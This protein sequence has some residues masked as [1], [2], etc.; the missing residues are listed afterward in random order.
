MIKLQV[1]D[2][3]FGDEAVT[4]R[5][6]KRVKGK[7]STRQ[8]PLTPLLKEALLAWLSI[9]PGHALFCHGDEVARSKK[10][11][12]STGH[13]SAPGRATSLTGRA[14]TVKARSKPQLGH[15]TTSEMHY[16]FRKTLCE[17]KWSVVK[18]SHVLRHSMISCMAAAGIDQRIIDDTVGHCSEEMRRRYRHLTPEVKQRSVT[19]VFG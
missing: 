17:S 1:T 19:A 10:R 4:I 18:G 11:R 9:H 12:H 5:E 7:R 16:H 2:L 13:Q 8:A 14:E 3:D 6:N 15:L